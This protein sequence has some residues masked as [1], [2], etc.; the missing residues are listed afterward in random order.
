MHRHAVEAPPYD[1]ARVAAWANETHA[2]GI[3]AYQ[4]LP[5]RAPDHNSASNPVVIDNAYPTAIKADADGQLLEGA[6]R[7]K[8]ILVDALA[9]LIRLG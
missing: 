1:E 2:L 4:L 6:A 3:K 8:A 9:P 7:L 5:T